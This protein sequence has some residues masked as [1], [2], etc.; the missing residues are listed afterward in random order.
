MA[1]LVLQLSV[2]LPAIEL[3]ILLLCPLPPAE[4]DDDAADTNGGPA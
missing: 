1:L 2:P 3:I 4:V